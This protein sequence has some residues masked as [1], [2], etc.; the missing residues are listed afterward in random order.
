MKALTVRQPYAELI[1]DGIKTLE[2]R[3]R[4]TRHRGPLAIHAAQTVAPEF[5]GI[6]WAEAYPR[7]LVVCVVNVVGCHELT[8]ADLEEAW[9]PDWFFDEVQGLLHAWELEN[10][11]RTEPFACKGALNL[12]Q[13]AT[14]PIIAA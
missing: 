14:E 4:P 2:V 3:S 6:D 13:L 1:A 8:T 12:W 7:G 11:R 9:L 10:P 5:R